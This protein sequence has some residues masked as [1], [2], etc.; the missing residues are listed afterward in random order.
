MWKGR[1]SESRQGGRDTTA[2]TIFCTHVQN[3]KTF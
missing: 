2:P 1:G 3:L